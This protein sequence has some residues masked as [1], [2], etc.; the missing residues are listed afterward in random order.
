MQNTS[1]LY[2]RIL[3]DPNHYFESSVVIGE[4]GDLVT[5]RGETILF[6]DTA[7][8]VSRSGPEF[9]YQM[10]QIFSLTTSLQMFRRQP[11]IGKVIAQEI[12]LKMLQP[13]GDVPPMAQ[14][15]LYTRACTDTLQ[16][17]WLQQGVFY[18]DTRETTASNDLRILTI[19]GFDAVL[20]LEQDYASTSINWPATDVSIV[21]EI[22]SKIGVSVDPRTPALMTGG[23]RYPLPTGYTL[24]EMLGY[25]AQA[26]IGCFIVTETG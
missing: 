11:E 14:V 7:I 2:R 23:Y 9:G 21:Q 4:G 10:S 19:H 22:A 20:M 17:E 5:E 24:R 25:I 3:A 1:S 16:S 18:I 12:E 6:G 26:Y 13:S 8:I 15:V